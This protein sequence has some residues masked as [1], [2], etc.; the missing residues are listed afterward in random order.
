MAEIG[1]VERVQSDVEN[2]KGRP[3]SKLELR[4][5]PTAFCRLYDLNQ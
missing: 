3:P 2:R 5:P 4:F 1:I